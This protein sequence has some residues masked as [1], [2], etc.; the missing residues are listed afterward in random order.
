MTREEKRA[1][2]EE[3]ADDVLVQHKLVYGKELIPA[4]ERTLT[5]ESLHK[6][7]QEVIDAPIGIRRKLI[8]LRKYCDEWG[9]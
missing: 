8:V 7:L 3:L 5:M 6:F 1:K 4:E 9:A 2:Q